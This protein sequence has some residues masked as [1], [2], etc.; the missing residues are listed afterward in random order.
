LIA[1]ALLIAGLLV[2]LGLVGLCLNVRDARRPRMTALV[3]LGIAVAAVAASRRTGT[4][5][6]DLVAW[7]V[8]GTAIP[9]LWRHR[10]STPDAPYN[11]GFWLVST[12]LTTSAVVLALMWSSR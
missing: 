10:E 7:L 9:G 1:D 12:G 3:A 8:A 6:G 2:T 4:H 11:G 5:S